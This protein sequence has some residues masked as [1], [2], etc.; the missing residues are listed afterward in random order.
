M[1]EPGSGTAA[2]VRR[3]LVTCEA[4]GE[5][6]A[7]DIFVV[8]RVLR[9]EAPR[10]MPNV[11]PWLR[12]VIDHGGRTIPVVELRERL[13]LPTVAADERSRILLLALPDGMVG[14]TVDAVLEV[15][16]VGS[17]ELEEPPAIYRGLTRDYLQAVARQGE[18]LFMV[19]DVTRLLTSTERIE[20]QQAMDVERTS[21]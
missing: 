9:W 11:A 5:R 7:L 17:E 12:G 2:P 4:A 16:T 8:E 1:T 18:R 20:M 15:L 10:M 19:L 3:Q 21:G 13:G 6:F 14:L